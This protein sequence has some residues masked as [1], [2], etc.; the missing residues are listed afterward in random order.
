MPFY[1]VAKWSQVCVDAAGTG[2]ISSQVTVFSAVT[3]PLTICLFA[4]FSNV[5]FR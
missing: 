5:H 4:L 2:A 3:S 1:S